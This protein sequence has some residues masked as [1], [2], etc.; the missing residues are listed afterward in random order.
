MGSG[1]KP[2][3]VL[4]GASG[5][6]KVV[7]DIIRREGKLELVGFLD[8]RNPQIKGAPFCGARVLGGGE[9]LDALLSDGVRQMILAFGDCS[10][11]LTLADRVRS[12]GFV[13]A[14]ALHP[15]AIIAADVRIGSGTV[16]M[17]GAVLNPGTTI[18]ENGIVNTGA[19]VDHDCR[20]ADGVHICPGA[21]LAGAVSVGRGSWVGVGATVRDHITIGS[22]VVVG[23]GALVLSDI[24]DGVVAY[25][26]PA[27][28][29][30][31]R[32]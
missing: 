4:W 6:A 7:A 23:A 2:K 14:T 29:K 26:V 16:V 12:A 20:L 27:K 25:G 5:H 1:V 18:G 13:L 31:E 15:D 3:V 17:A 24:P 32:K 22:D 30:G 19:I 21:V 10:A 28:V 11:R 9:V 8:D